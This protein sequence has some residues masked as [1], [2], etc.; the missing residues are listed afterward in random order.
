VGFRL[1][2][3]L[4]LGCGVERVYV[5]SSIYDE[6]LK[7]F[8]EVAKAYKLGDPSKPETN[9]G[10]VVSVAS[11]ARIRKQVKDAGESIRASV[12]GG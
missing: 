12:L 3:V 7:E 6:F 9:L 2:I 1:R 8:V 10:P 11:A 4:T 5:H